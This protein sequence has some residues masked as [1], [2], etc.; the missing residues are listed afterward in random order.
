M[1]GLF[2]RRLG[3]PPNRS[4]SRGRARYRALAVAGEKRV[5]AAEQT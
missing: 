3:A 1:G 4:R 2:L 5:A